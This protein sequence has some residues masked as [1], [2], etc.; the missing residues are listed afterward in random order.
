MNVDIVSIYGSDMVVSILNCVVI[1]GF[2]TVMSISSYGSYPKQI[3]T[4]N[5]MPTQHDE[6]GSIHLVKHVPATADEDGVIDMV[7]VIV[8]VI[9]GIA[10]VLVVT[11]AV[12]GRGDVLEIEH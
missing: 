3:T 10:L 4:S 9:D 2:L 8:L 7:T 5:R 11:M 6:H 1:A 12:V